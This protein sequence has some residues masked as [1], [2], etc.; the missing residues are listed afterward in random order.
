MC[1]PAAGEEFCQC[2]ADAIE[3]NIPVEEFPVDYL[4]EQFMSG[5]LGEDTSIDE[6]ID[7]NGLFPPEVMEAISPC[8]AL[9]PLEEL[10][11]EVIEIDEESL[12]D[13]EL[14]ETTEE[15]SKEELLAPV[16]ELCLLQG[17]QKFCECGIDAVSDSYTEDE[18]VALI[19]SVKEGTLPS[20]VFQLFL[21]N[22]AMY[23]GQ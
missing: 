15:M 19:E 8:S 1:V 10:I 11:E 12:E 3:E 4:M 2:S 23:L 16:S 14:P 5:S 20:N 17:S 13:I 6:L 22:C 21:M 18:L 9:L 7:E